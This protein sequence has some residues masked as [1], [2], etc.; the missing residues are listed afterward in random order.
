MIAEY[1]SSITSWTQEIINLPNTSSTY[2]IAFEGYDDFGYG[3]CVDDVEVAVSSCPAPSSL[4]ADNITQTSA[5]LN[6]TTGGASTWNIEYGP[7]GFTQGAGTMITGTTSNPYSL[8]GLSAGTAYD[9]YVQDDCGGGSQS[10]WSGP[11]S[12]T[13]ICVAVNTFPWT[14]DFENGGS[15]P[16]CWTEEYNVGSHDWVFQDGGYIYPLNAHSGSYN[17]AFIHENTSSSTKLITPPLDL[18]ALTN[19]QVSFWHAQVEDNFSGTIYQDELRVYYKTSSAGSWTLIPGAEY[20]SQVADWT[21]VILS[22]P[23]PSADYYIA[24]EGTDGDGQGVCI[25]DVEVDGNISCLPSTNLFANNIGSTSVDLNW[26][27]GGATTWNIEWG[28]AGFVQGNGTMIS[29]TTDNPY[30]LS[31]LSANTAYDF[32]VQD[33]CGGS[34]STWT[35]PATFCALI[36]IF[37]WTEGFENGGDRPDGWTEEYVSGTIDWEYRDGGDGGIP[38]NAYDGS[39]NAEFSFNTGDATMLITPVFD[40]TAM[41]DPIL[42]FWHTQHEFMGGL[43]TLTVYYRISESDPWTMVPGGNYTTEVDVWTSEVLDLPSPS[44]TYQIAFKATDGGGTGVCVDDVRIMDNTPMQWVSSTCTQNTGYSYRANFQQIIGIEIET[45]YMASP[46]EIT[47]F[48]VNTNGGSVDWQSI[49]DF[50]IYYTGTSS[51]FDERNLFNDETV[52]PTGQGLDYDINGSQIL[53]EG[54]NYFWLAVNVEPYAA[55]G[56][57]IDAECL[58]ITTASKAVYVPS[59]TAPSGNSEIHADMAWTGAISNNWDNTGNWDPPGPPDTFIPIVIP[60]G[61]S[62]SLQLNGDLVIHGYGGDY[63]CYSLEIQQAVTVTNTGRLDCFGDMDVAGTYTSTNNSS[64]SHKI[65]TGGELSIS[66]TGI[67]NIGNSINGEADLIIG[68]DYWTGGTLINTGGELYVADQ[69]YL[70]DNATVITGSQAIIFAGKGGGGSAYSSDNPATFYVEDGALGNI[71]NAT[72]KVCGKTEPGYNTVDIQSSDFDLSF[73]AIFEICHGDAATHY[74]ANVSIVDGADMVNFVINKPGNEVI[75]V[76]NLDCA[77]DFVVRPEA[78]FTVDAGNAISVAQDFKLESDAN[79]TASFINYGTLMVG[80]QTTMECRIEGYGGG[81]DLDGWHFLSS[82]VAGQDINPAFVQDPFDFYRWNEMSG[83]WQNFENT[84]PH[85]G[86]TNF[87]VGKGYLVAYQN[88]LSG[89]FTADANGFNTDN[90][91]GITLTNSGLDPQGFNLLGNPYP[92]ALTWDNSIGDVGDWAKIW[93]ESS[94]SYVDIANGEVIPALNGFMVYSNVATQ[95]VTISASDRTHDAQVW[96]KNES[97][98][99]KLLAHDL[100]QDVYQESIILFEDNASPGFDAYRDSKFLYG[101]APAFYS[102]ADEV[103]TSVNAMAWNQD[104]IIPFNFEK[105]ASSNFMIE[106]AES[107]EGMDVYLK[108]LKTNTSINLS[109]YGTYAFTSAEGD[110][111]YRFEILFVA[112]GIE[113]MQPLAGA[114]IYCDGDI[115]TIDNVKGEIRMDIINIQGCIMQSEEFRSN[116]HAVFDVQLPGGIYLVRI[117]NNGEAKTTKVFVK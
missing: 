43:S 87:E 49:N 7:E 76:S 45:Q 46:I 5:N 19:P 17:A 69:I 2:Y 108:D 34:Q 56:E 3:V 37:P 81:S 78:Q 90:V 23:N 92:S 24:F 47:S 85:P 71:M 53:T 8:S 61:T 97:Q 88:N 96:Y 62:N 112:A 1:T 13:T 32:Y 21:E 11:S 54:T 107:I 102:L 83:E 14:E 42:D 95:S 109:A 101:Y 77:G 117:Y 40:L 66:T 84:P 31:G 50:S 82:P 16:D 58:Q 106:L 99:I 25:D 70:H 28:P 20:T 29:G 55:L 89:V 60:Y 111:P 104:L 75:L 15:R 110:D 18:S 26:T 100:E 30:S 114:H 93:Q 36:N 72:I 57:T 94:A 33:D 9:F 68:H 41:G 44:T 73:D 91:S 52:D 98:Q 27:T 79:R 22:L 80:G 10:S 35:G 38:A 48:R 59:I 115:L 65:N 116:G 6:W 12:F 63:N 51:V 74:D 86:F 39:Y 64:N 67:V 105:N 113:V 4:Y 103:S